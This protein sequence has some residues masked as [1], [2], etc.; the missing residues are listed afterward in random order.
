MASTTLFS[1]PLYR[2]YVLP[3]DS[4][5]VTLSI[6]LRGQFSLHF[7]KL[8]MQF[9]HSLSV[10]FFGY[11]DGKTVS[12]YS[13][14][15]RNRVRPDVSREIKLRILFTL[16]VNLWIRTLSNHYIGAYKGSTLSS[17]GFLPVA[18]CT[19]SFL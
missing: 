3:P 2:I 16:R 12:F 11:P 14:S 4:K 5:S 17:L 15:V 19:V 6:E 13:L 18:N 7:A 1:V 9:Y 10:I 8:S